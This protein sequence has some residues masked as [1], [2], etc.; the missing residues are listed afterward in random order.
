MVALICLKLRTFQ[1]ISLNWTRYLLINGSYDVYYIKLILNLDKLDALFC[2]NF[3]DV[4]WLDGVL[5]MIVLK[6]PFL[7]GL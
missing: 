1:A 4:E 6:I 5:L 3:F 7:E 2:H